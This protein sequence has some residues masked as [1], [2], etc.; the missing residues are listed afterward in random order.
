MGLCLLYSAA[1]RSKR[2]QRPLVSPRRQ[3]S[4][5]ES[6]IPL[7][8][9]LPRLK[10]DHAAD[11]FAFPHQGESFVD[12]VKRHRMGDHRVDLNPSLHV[13][14][15][16]FRHV[17]TAACAAKGGAAPDSPRHQLKWSCGNFLACAGDT[18]DD[19]LSP[20]AMAAFKRSEERRVRK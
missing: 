16:D 19:A 11:R 14:L 1:P 2:A 6:E 8:Y 17:G 20:A 7:T 13:P 9:Y 4:R 15:H 10:N 5:F 18:D 12:A 3:N